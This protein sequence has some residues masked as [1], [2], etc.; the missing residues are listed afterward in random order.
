M[1]DMG[2]EVAS[3]EAG[4]AAGRCGPEHPGVGYLSALV[5]E[6][7][8]ERAA[9]SLPDAVFLASIDG[10]AGDESATLGSL[11][12]RVPGFTEAPNVPNLAELLTNIG[13][14]AQQVAGGRASPE[15]GRRSLRLR[16][17][18]DA[19]GVARRPA[20]QGRSRGRPG[21]GSAP[22]TAR[23]RRDGRAPAGTPLIRP[24]RS[25]TARVTTRR[26][27]SAGKKRSSQHRKNG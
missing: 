16:A 25:P 1:P 24:A 17:L 11:G 26:W 6:P 20:D 7:T 10:L 27:N 19:L 3:A 14:A 9:A 12:D 8:W 4:R 5:A 21:N 13:V 18:D 23:A 22:G 2:F 15:V